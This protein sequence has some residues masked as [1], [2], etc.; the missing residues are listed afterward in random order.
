MM[1]KDLKQRPPRLRTAATLVGGR[2]T[3]AAT[4]TA[5]CAVT[6]AALVG[7]VGS[8]VSAESGSAPSPFWKAWGDGKAEVAGYSLRQPR[9]GAP[10]KGSLV[11]IYV[12]EDMTESL[13]VKADPGQHQD[14]YPVLKL[15]ALRKFQTGIYDYSVMTSVF[16][17]LEASGG[18]SLRKVSF[19]S[20]EWCGHVYHQLLPRG[21]RLESTSHSYFDG[22]ADR[23]ESLPL[24]REAGAGAAVALSEDELPLILRPYVGRSEFLAPGG[25][26]TVPLIASLL[27]VR[28]SHKPIAIADATIERRPGSETV[29]TPAGS[30]AVITYQVTLAGDRGAYQF[31]AAPPHR[32][33]RYAWESGEEALLRGSARLPYWQLNQ[34]G[35]ESYLKQLGLAPVPAE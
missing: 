14:I 27:R 6:C 17:R 29:K 9:Y 32:L 30:F 28:L 26:K 5:S 13:R 35:G 3:F 22:E 15:N 24:P 1:Q 34:P 20:Q 7:S 21:E 19:S 11:L 18:L 10:R 2:W 25:K 4:L 16:D 12:T 23:T 31:E 8:A 33:V